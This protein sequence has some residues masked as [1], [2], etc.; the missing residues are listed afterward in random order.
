MK[1]KY[2]LEQ[3]QNAI[4]ISNSRR[5]LLKNLHIV[6]G[7]GNYQTINKFIK[8]NNLDI[9]HFSR[10]AWNK[11]KKTKYKTRP[12]EDYLSNRISITSHKLRLRLLSEKVFPHKCNKCKLT[13]WLTHPI[14]L[15]L[16]HKDGN[17]LNNN[18]DN[19]ELLCPN[20]HAFTP[21]YR[22]KNVSKS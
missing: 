18:L 7:G 4:L 11:G 16:E 1:H 12:I 14:P 2:T 8:N 15:E 3:V 10:I 17:H 5:E 13:T 22:G 21:T 6:S 9:S 20:C 19:L